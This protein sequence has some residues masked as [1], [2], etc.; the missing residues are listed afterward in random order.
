ME[1]MAYSAAMMIDSMLKMFPM[2][3]MKGLMSKAD[4]KI[5][6]HYI[7]MDNE[8]F[9]PTATGVPLRIAL[10]GTFT[11]GVK[12]GLNIAGDMS[13]IAFMPSAGIEFTTQIGTFIPEYVNSRLEMHTNLFH[14]SGLSAKISMG[15]NEVKFTMPAPKNPTKLISIANTFVAVN[16]AEVKT[17]PPM[18]E[19]KVDV[20][21]CTPL[22]AGMKYCTSLMYTDAYNYETP[23]FPFTGDSKLAV[24]LHPTGEVTEYSASIS[25]ELVTEEEKVDILKMVLAA[26]GAGEA[27]ATV[28]YNRGKNV[29]TTDFQ[30]PDYDL[31][32]GF[33]LGVVDANTK[34][35]GAYA[36]SLD[37]INK[38]IPQL[39]L[40]ARAKVATMEEAM[41]Q[42]QLLVPLMR[43]DASLTA[44]LKRG[45]TLAF[46]LA[47][48]IKLPET[49]SLQKISLKYDDSKIEAEVKSEMN[50]Q[51]QKL[52]PNAEA[53][54]RIMNEVL[55]MRV[56]QTDMK[57]R[58][59]ITMSVEATNNYMDK[60]V[61]D[62]PYITYMRLPAMPEIT[63]PEKLFFNAEA[64]A[65]YNFNNERFSIAI[66]LPLGGKSTTADLNF[67]P[68]LA[69]PSLSLPQFGL[70]VGSIE[71]PLP[72]LSVP[73]TVSVPLFGKAEASAK[74]S[75]N[76]YELE[77]S[78]AL[79]KDAADTPTYLA[80]FEME[81]TSPVDILS[82]KMEGSGLLVG[83]PSDSLKAHVKAAVTH[84]LLEASVSIME[85]GTF[86]D[87]ISVKSS[88]K[89]VATSPIGMLI[90]LEH[91]GTVGF[92]A[93]ELSADCNLEGSIKAG[94][95]YGNTIS[96]QAFSIFPFRPEA[97][98]DSSLKID[99][100]ILKAQNTIAATFVNGELNVASNT[101][102]FE[103]V[104]TQA[105]ELSFKENKLAL[106]CDTNAIVFGMKLRSQAGASAATDEVII[107]IE[108]N[109][110]HSDNR[111]F[112]LL[113]AT[114]DVNGLVLS[115]DATVKLLENEA[116]QK[117]YSENKQRMV[118]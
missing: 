13:E 75:T 76:L 100:T 87:T 95:I 83:T 55:D 105:A 70:E 116:V 56:G 69:T 54:E 46:E 58:Q 85:V 48:D 97:K 2:D 42:L 14:E 110:D 21:E 5:F 12:G 59:I 6:A 25:Y 112:S 53:V 94:P 68:A 84:K 24:E 118:G 103:D 82:V 37:L 4:N 49:T 108:T 47:S 35:N 92:N 99:T 102:A 114:L 9:L 11:P 73:K 44:N 30:I 79:G 77:V 28:M 27:T 81:G 36:V 64:H 86:A 31:E 8:F 39:S 106:T 78:A 3:V 52:L 20:S 101:N 29:L 109:A 26:E 41:L 67:P 32:A 91:T 18:V 89:I 60:Y 72:E 111:I 15:S 43:A 16:G 63:M 50:S 93:E 7:F 10:S 66:P 90:E 107:K 23:Y 62:I 1:S 38:N 88:S 96:T 33:R 45:E 113:T 61:S 71:I 65:A 17:I 22:F 19:D 74:A 51:I 57:V 80:K 34:G 117:N 115:S 104:L 40:I 98:I